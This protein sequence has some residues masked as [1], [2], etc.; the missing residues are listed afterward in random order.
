[1]GVDLAGHIYNQRGLAVGGLEI[2]AFKDAE[3]SATATT[4]T[5][6]EGYWGFTDLPDGTYH[7]VIANKGWVQVVHSGDKVQFDTL[8]A[9]A[10]FRL[11][12][13]AQL[14]P[15]VGECYFDDSTDKLMVYT[16][17]GWKGVTLA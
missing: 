13:A 6:A 4:Y 15:G 12:T 5:D 8:K 16:T 14:A 9:N 3:T 7:V 17:A 1:M 2:K 10:R 11:P